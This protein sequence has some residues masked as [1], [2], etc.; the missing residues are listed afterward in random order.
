MKWLKKLG[1]PS[2]TMLPSFPSIILIVTVVFFNRFSKVNLVGSPATC[3][4]TC[5]SIIVFS[6]AG[7]SLYSVD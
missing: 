5:Y 3:L 1:S 6:R 2:K 7:S 4:I